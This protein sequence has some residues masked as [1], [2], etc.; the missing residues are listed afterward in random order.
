M[1]NGSES[2]S[3][4]ML[5][6]SGVCFPK[7]NSKSTLFMNLAINMKAVKANGISASLLTP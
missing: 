2:E 7:S 6:R 1:S 4:K 3:G 5:K